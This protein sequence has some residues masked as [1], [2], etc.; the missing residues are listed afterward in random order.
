MSHRIKHALRG[1]WVIPT[2]NRLSAALGILVLV[3]LFEKGLYGLCI[4]ECFQT[5]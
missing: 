1:R 2:W 3:H 4:D 5:A